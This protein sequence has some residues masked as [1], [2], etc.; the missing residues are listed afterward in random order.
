MEERSFLFKFVVIALLIGNAFVG[1]AYGA[2]L[3]MALIS[4][5]ALPIFEFVRVPLYFIDVVAL[6]MFLKLRVIGFKIIIITSIIYSLMPLFGVL[7][8]DLSLPSFGTRNFYMLILTAIIVP[9]LD[10]GLLYFV[11]KNH[12]TKR[13]TRT[14]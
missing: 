6:L 12:I 2:A 3:Y 14:P 13:S 5:E 1:L 10:V 7:F 4:E 8:S 11:G 9:Y